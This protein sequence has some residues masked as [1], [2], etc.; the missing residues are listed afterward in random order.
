[1]ADENSLSKNCLY[2]GAPLLAGAHFC[3]A[4][5]QPATGPVIESG[6]PELSIPPIPEPMAPPLRQFSP[7]PPVDV[8]PAASPLPPVYSPPASSSSALPRWLIPTIVGLLVILCL[9]CCVTGFILMWLARNSSDSAYWQVQS[10]LVVAIPWY[11]I[12]VG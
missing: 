6:P 12:V 2:C 1:M 4:C 10:L 8:P 9:C 11:G 3:E 7:P 5:G